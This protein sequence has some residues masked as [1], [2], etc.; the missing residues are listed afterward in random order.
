MGD[1]GCGRKRPASIDEG[2]S[3]KELTLS[4]CPLG[5]GTCVG[6]APKL[7]PLQ[8]GH[9]P[10]TEEEGLSHQERLGHK[11]AAPKWWARI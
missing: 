11:A 9:S 8:G 4:G 2:S 3:D 10:V 5:P 7:S 1:Q 6:S